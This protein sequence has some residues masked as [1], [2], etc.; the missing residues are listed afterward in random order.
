M[1]TMTKNC[2][3]NSAVQALAAGDDLAWEEFMQTPWYCYALNQMKRE[4][5]EDGED[6]M[7]EVLA[8]L[9][10]ALNRYV[11]TDKP[12]ISLKALFMKIADRTKNSYLEKCY[13]RS[14]IATQISLGAD[15]PVYRQMENKQ[16]DYEQLEDKLELISYLPGLHD[17]I[18]AAN[19]K[20]EEWEII[21]AFYVYELSDKKIAI[22]LNKSVNT[23]KSKRQ[24]AMARLRKEFKET[25]AKN[26]MGGIA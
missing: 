22:Q 18:S 13:R 1:T 25:G 19:I 23:I 12:I 4:F 7:Q 20:L 3:L 2:A 14:K 26:Y 11:N 9:Y 5:K 24:R 10:L 15:N 8:D 21:V 16:S 17:A 6:L